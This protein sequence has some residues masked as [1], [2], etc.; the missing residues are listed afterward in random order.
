[1]WC[2]VILLILTI[3]WVCKLWKIVRTTLWKAGAWMNKPAEQCRRWPRVHFVIDLVTG[4]TWQKRSSNLITRGIW[5]FSQCGGLHRKVCSNECEHARWKRIRCSFVVEKCEPLPASAFS[6]ALV[7]FANPKDVFKPE[8][9]L[10]SAIKGVAENKTLC[11]CTWV[12]RGTLAFICVWVHK[13]ANNYRLWR[14]QHVSTSRSKVASLTFPFSTAHLS[15][16]FNRRRSTERLTP[17]FVSCFSPTA[18]ATC[19]P[20]TWYEQSSWD[21]HQVPRIYAIRWCISLSHGGSP[22]RHGDMALHF[23]ER[24][25]RLDVHLFVWR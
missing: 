3:V 11:F 9:W 20:A 6:D 15:L 10:R 18:P 19:K 1:M 23:V 13:C 2:D 24:T 21:P 22:F 4:R 8:L 12:G 7:W 16:S 14:S 5:S 25:A 17:P